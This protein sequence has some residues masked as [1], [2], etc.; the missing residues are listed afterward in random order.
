MKES[1]LSLKDKTAQHWF[2]YL[3]F[4]RKYSKYLKTDPLNIIFKISVYDYYTTGSNSAVYI[5]N[6][7]IIS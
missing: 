4:V 6:K 2:S 3:Q 5:L 1:V 7:G